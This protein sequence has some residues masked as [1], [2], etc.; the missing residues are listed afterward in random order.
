MNLKTLLGAGLLAAAS[1]LQSA[2][3]LAASDVLV[4]GDPQ[5]KS[6]EDVGYFLNDIVQPLQGSHSARLGLSLGDLVD[7]APAHYPALLAVF[8]RLGI[9]RV[10]SLSE[11]LETL[12]IASL[13]ELP[14]GDRIGVLTCSGGD[15]AMLADSLDHYKLQLP[16]LSK[17]QEQKLGEWLPDFAS[18]RGNYLIF[19]NGLN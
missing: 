18:F 4:F 5:V 10:H 16:S 11:L 17:I 3:A 6:P 9:L 1:L 15:S 14:K 7:D 12:K 8:D 19:I 13:C 2:Q